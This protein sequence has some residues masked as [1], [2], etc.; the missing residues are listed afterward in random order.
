[1]IV[2]HSYPM[3]NSQQP[4]RINICRS[5]AKF[6]SFSRKS[7]QRREAKDTVTILGIGIQAH[8]K[9]DGAA[10]VGRVEFNMNGG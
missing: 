3:R 1:M 9:A 10:G 8:T 2:G 5:R 6:R 4:E 7:R